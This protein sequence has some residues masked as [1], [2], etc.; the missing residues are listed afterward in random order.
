MCQLV[1]SG[2]ILLYSNMYAVHVRK[3]LSTIDTPLL[4]IKKT[5]ARP[6]PVCVRHPDLSFFFMLRKELGVVPP[7][8]TR[9]HSTRYQLLVRL[10]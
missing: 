6:S 2:L 9:L 1:P 8:S 3:E 7:Y 10:L 4:K 5:H